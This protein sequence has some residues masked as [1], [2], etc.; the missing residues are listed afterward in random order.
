MTSLL[1]VLPKLDDVLPGVPN[2]DLKK[3]VEQTLAPLDEIA[4]VE[5]LVELQRQAR[6]LTDYFSK[7]EQQSLTMKSAQ[8]RIARRIGA[9]LTQTVRLENP[10]LSKDTTTGQLPEAVTRDQSSKWQKLAEMPKEFFEAY[11]AN[12][13]KPSLNG[14]LRYAI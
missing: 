13:K 7:S 2:A 11:L 4:D 9:V 5:R 3:T 10:H 6:A 8:L 1:P 12:A 14:V